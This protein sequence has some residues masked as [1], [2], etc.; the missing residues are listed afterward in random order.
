[1]EAMV[2]TIQRVNA[3]RTSAAEVAALFEG[4]AALLDK[5]FAVGVMPVEKRRL[6][7]VRWNL[8]RID[9]AR[10]GRGLDAYELAVEAAS[11]EGEVK[12][13]AVC[14]PAPASKDR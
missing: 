6:A 9:D 12:A 7:Y 2:K 13:Y 14:V 3:G 5:Q 10:A 8:D 4:R 1:M 11:G